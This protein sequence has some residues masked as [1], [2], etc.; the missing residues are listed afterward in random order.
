MKIAVVLDA[1]ISPGREFHSGIV[2]GM[3]ECLRGGL[4]ALMG[5]SLYEV[6]DPSSLI[7]DAALVGRGA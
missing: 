5:L 6:T 3:V 7:I 1:R 2:A 4:S